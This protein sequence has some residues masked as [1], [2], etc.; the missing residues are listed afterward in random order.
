A[1]HTAASGGEST[2]RRRHPVR[3]L[4]AAAGVAAAAAVIAF[5]VLPAVRGTDTAT[6]SDVLA[7]MS[8]PAVKA[9][10]VRLTIK[11]GVTDDSSPESPL[12]GSEP[13]G[14]TLILSSAGDYRHTT[15]GHHKAIGDRPAVTTT[16]TWTYDE[17]GHKMMSLGLVEP[18][19]GASVLAIERPSWGSYIWESEPYAD[20]QGLASTLRARLA[21]EDPDSPVIETTY[22]G[23]PAWSAD[24][25]ERLSG[26]DGKEYETHWRVVV[27]KATG[28]LMRSDYGGGS[29]TSKL[30]FWVTRIELDPELPRNWQ[31]I[32]EAGLPRVGIEDGGTR[33]GTP[34]SV[35]K[36]TWPTLV[37]VPQRIPQ[38][39]RLTDVAST[40]F[41]GMQRSRKLGSRL[42]YLS[43]RPKK[44]LRIW[45]GVDESVQR[46]MLRYRRGFSTFTIDIRP[47]GSRL[48]I[49]GPNRIQDATDVRLSAGYLSGRTASTSIAP[50]F[51]KGPTLIVKSDRSTITI[52]GDL[53]RNEM[54]A[55]ANSMK[56][57]GDVDKPLPKGYGVKKPRPHAS[58][59][60]TPQ[61]SA[62]SA[63]KGSPLKPVWS[64]MFTS[65]ENDGFTAVATGPDGAVYAAGHARAK[66]P[67]AGG[68]LL[69][70]KYVD[71][72]AT[73]SEAWR[74]LT[75]SEPTSAQRVAVDPAG[76]VI[77]AG[78][79]GP[80]DLSGKGSDLVVL[81]VSAAGKVLWKRSY[82]GPSHLSD[83][84][85][86]LALDAHGNALVVGAST[87]KGTA[88]DYITVKL[89]TDGSVAWA[90]RYAG[91]QRFDE[92]RS[93][94]VDG[95]GNVYVAG[96]SDDKDSRRRATTI[97]YSPDGGQ[98]WTAQDKTMG[99]WS[100]AMDVMVSATDGPPHVV[101]TGYQGVGS[102]EALM[103]ARYSA[104]TGELIWKR[105]LRSSAQAR[106]P[107]A[108]AVD[109][110]GAPVA[111]GEA[112]LSPRGGAFIAGV[113]ANGSGPWGI[114]L[115]SEVE[116]PGF[117]EF[118][119]V[120]TGP[121][122]AILAGGYVQ[123]AKPA[124]QA[125]DYVPTSFAV[126]YSPVS[127][128]TAP[129]DY[130]GAGSP[131]TRGRCTAVAIGASGMYAVGERTTGR[132]DQD[133]V[134]VKF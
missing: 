11:E 55:L 130:V 23:R 53:T 63:V 117:A 77:V 59:S 126:R 129:L 99:S 25:K 9:K 41:D 31:R 26:R 14:E 5:V 40:N 72:G 113:S 88:R 13:A 45:T 97:C 44:Y 50:N 133:A 106:E 2:R 3:W 17:A 69:L 32:S 132:G 36:R 73:A 35:A 118:D 83:Y 15:V 71:R 30:S 82:D 1:S 38:G 103:F 20:F 134:L 51:G 98:R 48:P 105:L 29:S 16:D 4:V 34:Q 87:G 28:L 37:L 54:I 110:S 86:D 60:A 120:A 21:E 67:G 52:N 92:A 95:E 19:D 49:P 116:D 66:T 119:A 85:T 112:N 57:Y 111:V 70:V 84:V 7:A 64:S 68:K 128:V 74:V 91:P 96:W 76:N 46:V 94:G 109:G 104:A 80:I 124:K 79:Q 75:G 18:D 47:N 131:T 123:T 114:L 27:D 65:A 115:S 8:S 43:Y 93:V 24:L 56:A 125:W 6:A 33:F 78:T 100:G 89:R 101:I 108:G 121:R 42:V 10:T 61:P 102:N 12:P 62:S 107:E 122:G 127:P 81:K 58:K 22:L 90:R 39:Y